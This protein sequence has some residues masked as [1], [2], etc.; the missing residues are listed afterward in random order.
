MTPRWRGFAIRAFVYVWH[1]LQI[2][3]SE[4]QRDAVKYLK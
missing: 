2:R 4:S 1:R 3:A